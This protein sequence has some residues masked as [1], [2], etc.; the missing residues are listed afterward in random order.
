MKA[1]FLAQAALSRMRSLAEFTLSEAE[2]LGMTERGRAG[3]DG[4]SAGMTTGRVRGMAGAGAW[5]MRSK[6]AQNDG[7]RDCGG[8]CAPGDWAVER[9]ES[10]AGRGTH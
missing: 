4:R 7:R 2:G 1:R 8:A 6:I 3:N 9:V 5:R 10:I